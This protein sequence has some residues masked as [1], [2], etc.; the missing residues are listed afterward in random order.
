LPRI[1]REI[2]IRPVRGADLPTANA[3]RFPCFDGKQPRRVSPEQSFLR[4][5]GSTFVRIEGL[6]LSN[7]WPEVIQLVGPG[8]I[9]LVR[10]RIDGGRHVLHASARQ[11]SEASHHLPFE[12]NHWKQDT[13]ATNEL[14]NRVPFWEAHDGAQRYWNGA[15]LRT[16]QSPGDLILRDNLVE[17][18]FD[19]I[20][21]AAEYPSTGSKPEGSLPLEAYRIVNGV[22]IQGRRNVN[23]EILAVAP[24]P[25]LC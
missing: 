16:D 11:A 4:L 13:S 19:A 7:Y 8:Y 2:V 20:Y 23:V 24:G 18:A 1:D 5:T 22:Q 9:S 14:W 3:P 15:L 12:G 21:T 10:S 17:D 25:A 6:C